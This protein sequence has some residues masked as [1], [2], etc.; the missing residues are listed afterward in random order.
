MEKASFRLAATA[1]L[2]RIPS[3]LLPTLSTQAVSTIV[4]LNEWEQA[5]SV[6]LFVSSIAREI[7]TDALIADAR[8]RGKRIF[9]PAVIGKK[10]C[11]MVF[12]ELANDE[13]ARTTCTFTRVLGIPQ[14]PKDGRAEWNSAEE[15][16]AITSSLDFI[17]VPGVAFDKGGGR[18]G[19]GRGYYDAFLAATRRKE[20]P[21]FALGICFDE[22]VVEEES[23]VP[24]G[25]M[26]EIL[27]GLVTPTR[28]FRIDRRGRKKH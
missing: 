15:W 21:P 12:R 8:A 10:A 2:S 17:L 26:D 11:D 19:H 18:V 20:T 25:D 6:A 23:G 4:S 13:D 3:L 14:P 22:Q 9:L 5:R 24:M 7:D 16:P 1:S 28:L 27:D